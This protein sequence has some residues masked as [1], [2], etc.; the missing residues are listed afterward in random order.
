[1]KDDY[2]QLLVKE[3]FLSLDK[4][5]VEWMVHF[6]SLVNDYADLVYSK[7]PD[8]QRLDEIIREVNSSD[9]DKM[10]RWA[11]SSNLVEGKI[12]DFFEISTF[13]WG[14]DSL[15]Y[16]LKY[17]IEDY[18]DENSVV[19]DLLTNEDKINIIKDCIINNDGY[20]TMLHYYQNKKNLYIH[21]MVAMHGQAG[22]YLENL[23]ISNSY[24]DM[25]DCYKDEYLFYDEDENSNKKIFSHSD[26]ELLELF[27][28]HTATRFSK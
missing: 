1:M 19:K 4:D 20:E 27:D 24:S 21:G 8:K 9:T 17:R 16:I 2:S 12:A 11:W 5:D 28:K 7:D 6:G 23:Y 14:T 13:F 18:F 10:Q 3:E 26:K 22:P 15:D 25:I